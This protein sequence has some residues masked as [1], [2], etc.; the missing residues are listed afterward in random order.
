MGSDSTFGSSLLSY[1]HC[2]HCYMDSQMYI[3]RVNAGSLHLCRCLCTNTCPEFKPWIS[4]NV[5]E[6]SEYIMGNYYF[7]QQFNSLAP[8]RFERKFRWIIFMV[9]LVIDGWDVHCEIALWW[10]FFYTSY[11]KLT[12][13]QVMAW[14]H[15]AP[16]HYLSQCWPRSVWSYGISSLQ[17]VSLLRPWCECMCQSV[18]SSLV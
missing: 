10:L 9:I 1:L 2:N 13:V 15:Q 5:C 11:D 18:K 7:S 4:F 3:Q 8:G 14:C 12:L 17:W 6:I 16:S